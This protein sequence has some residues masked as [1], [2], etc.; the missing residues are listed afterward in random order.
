MALAEIVSFARWPAL[1]SIKRMFATA[2]GYALNQPFPDFSEHCPRSQ[3]ALDESEFLGSGSIA[4][5]TQPN[6]H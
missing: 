4:T 6:A 1:T 2:F 3:E 5:T